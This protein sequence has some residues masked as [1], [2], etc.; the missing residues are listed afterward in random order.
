M[1]AD[2]DFADC[3]IGGSIFI[4]FLFSLVLHDYPEASIWPHVI[5]GLG[6]FLLVCGIVYRIICYRN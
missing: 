2:E 6:I 1:G 3:L 4:I 5:R